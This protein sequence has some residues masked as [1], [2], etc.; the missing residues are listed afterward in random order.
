M[1]KINNLNNKERKIQDRLDELAKLIQNHNFLYHQEDNPIIS[2]LEYD[3]LIKEN[4]KLEKEYP[5]LIS[6]NSPNKKV[7][8]SLSTK[9]DKISHKLPMLSLANA[10]N[11]KDLEDF[12]KRV[13]KFLILDNKK[14]L[15][16]ICEPKI[17]GLS[18]NLYYKNGILTSASTRGDGKI[19]ENVTKNIENI[20]EIPKK[21]YS[22]NVPD[23]IEIRG[24]IFLNK[25][26]FLK[27]NNKL[28]DNKFS[29]PRNAAAG[30]LR[31]LNPSITKQ[32]PL[33][34]IAHGLGYSSKNYYKVGDF[35]KDLNKWK[36]PVN[37]FNKTCNNL[38]CLIEFFN[39]LN[40]IR[41]KILYDVDGIVFKINDF[42]LQKRLGF[43]GKNPRWAIALKF[44]AEK[45]TT[46]IKKI[47]FQ[48]G[49]TGAITP[50]ARLEKINIGGV[51]VSNATL[52]NFDEILK[53]DIREGDIVEVQRAGDVIPQ[54][55]R[56]VKKE[57]ER[58]SL[59]K[60]LDICPVC[61]KKTIKEKDEAIIRCENTNNCDAQILGSLIHFVS[62]KSLNVEGLGEKQIKQ[63]YE[64]GFVKNFMDI[65]YIEKYKKEIL[66]L[67]GWG[68]LSYNNLIKS[69]N[70]SK[71]I[72]LDKFI[73]SLGIRFIGETISFILAKEFT[74]ANN[75]IKNLINKETLFDIDGIGPKAVSSLNTYFNNKENNKIVSNLI[76]TLNISDFVNKT[77]NSLFYNKNIVF[78]GTLSKLSREEAKHLAIELGAKI[79]SS[80]S[81]KTD[82]IIIG[83][84]PGTKARKAK[85]FGVSVLTEQEWIKKTNL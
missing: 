47:D 16:F 45:S 10:F 48:V 38:D 2:D 69:I 29:N 79:S 75:F 4:D 1:K 40:D 41:H 58:K 43:V 31:Q 36:I 51:V 9:F 23:E 30:S 50:V 19:G 80:V 11:E 81:T 49:R 7:G 52:H 20:K 5:H 56:V 71:N 62:K 15:E 18:I 61:G 13:K 24:E 21:L 32:R 85:E 3:K 66:K 33:K 17:D 46:R 65:F 28:K 57:K 76:K 42:S 84:K 68:D 8:S 70:Y 55:L 83:D 72:K 54:I 27:L 53:K 64:I 67:D 26:D 74:S 22:K 34:F 12:I 73:Y 35:Y 44:T 14:N 6:S 82:F 60:P 25:D 78:T 77:S 39:Y 63:F 59:I 37:K